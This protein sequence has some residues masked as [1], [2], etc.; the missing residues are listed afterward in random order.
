MTTEPQHV[1]AHSSRDSQSATAVAHIRPGETDVIDLLGIHCAWKVTEAETGGHYCMLEMYVPP[2][3]G[4]PMHQHE[5]QESF[6][7]IEGTAEFT[8]MG[9]DGRQSAEWFPV[10]RGETVHVPS[11]AMHGFRNPGMAPSRILLICAKGIEPFFREAGTPVAS[12]AALPTSPPSPESI[13]RVIGIATQSGQR[14][15]PTA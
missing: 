4:V 1:A 3:A 12:G 11:W 6:V 5:E 8:R 13:A 9:T 10:G 7:V 14:F 15:A 2:A